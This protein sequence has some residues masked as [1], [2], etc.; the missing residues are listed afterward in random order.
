MTAYLS[1]LTDKKWGKT[2]YPRNANDSL[3]AGLEEYL[4]EKQK[5]TPG[6]IAL[7]K[8]SA[9]PYHCGIVTDYKNSLGLLHAY[10][11]AKR[12]TEHALINWW[13]DKIVKVYGFP[14]V[15]YGG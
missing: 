11:N 5:L 7:F 1:G 15:D 9:I 10:E 2:N 8:I 4:I 12:V 13:K 3:R 14:G 6:C